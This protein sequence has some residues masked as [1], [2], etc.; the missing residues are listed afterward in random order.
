MP[1]NERQKQ[2]FQSIQTALDDVTTD[3]KAVVVL[4]IIVAIFV[5]LTLGLGYIQKNRFRIKRELIYWSKRLRGSTG[6]NYETRFEASYPVAI[7]VGAPN[8]PTER[9]K[10][11][12][13]SPSGMFV[14]SHQP[15]PLNSTFEFII[16][17]GEKEKIHG[18]ALVRWRQ[19]NPKDSLPAGMGC[20]FLN[21][22]EKEKNLIRLFLR[23][24]DTRNFKL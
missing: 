12:N 13:L 8:K 10:T 7:V 20:E 3:K 16:H 1:V 11:V 17:L 24:R 22:T 19:E 21:F 15:L 18:N 9:A 4:L 5:G 2:F 14:R 23:K 6:G